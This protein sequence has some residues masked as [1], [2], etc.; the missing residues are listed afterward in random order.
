MNSEQTPKNSASAELALP[1]GWLNPYLHLAI[2]G[3][4]VTVSDLGIMVGMGRNSLLYFRFYKLAAYIA[5]DSTQPRLS[6]D[7]RGSCIDS[8]GLLVFSW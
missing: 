4:L 3:L 6:S 2:N 7:K 1:T 5:M 8:A